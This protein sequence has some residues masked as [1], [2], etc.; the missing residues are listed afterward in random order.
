MAELY[1]QNAQAGEMGQL[2]KHVSALE[3][4]LL[5]CHAEQGGTPNPRLGRLRAAARAR[6]LALKKGEAAVTSSAAQLK[7]SACLRAAG[8]E[9][10]NA[11]REGCL[12]WIWRAPRRA[13]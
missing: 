5:V 3:L 6:S 12:W 11:W 10:E 1:L 4:E 8:W 13:W 2:L 9:H 7:L